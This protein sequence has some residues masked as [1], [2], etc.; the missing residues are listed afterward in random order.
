MVFFSSPLAGTPI[1]EALF[2]GHATVQF[3]NSVSGAGEVLRVAV[4]VRLFP[5]SRKDIG[6][7]PGVTVPAGPLVATNSGR[8]TLKV[9]MASGETR[10][11]VSVLRTV[12]VFVPVTGM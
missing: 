4:T 10:P 6:E 3:L 7:K 12:T 5:T 2:G 9:R 11:L 1:C 8:N